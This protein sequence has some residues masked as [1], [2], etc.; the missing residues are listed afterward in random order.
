LASK[1]PSPRSTAPAPS[2]DSTLPAATGPSNA[3]YATGR[4]TP[5]APGGRPRA[6]ASPPPGTAT[7]SLRLV[8]RNG[9]NSRPASPAHARLPAPTRPS[10]YLPLLVLTR[11][12]ETRQHAKFYLLPSPWSHGGH[13]API[14]H[15]CHL[16]L[17]R[18]A[19]TRQPPYI[20]SPPP[21]P[22][23]CW[24]TPLTRR[25]FG[26]PWRSSAPRPAQQSHPGCAWSLAHSLPRPA[27]FLALASSSRGAPPPPPLA[28]PHSRVLHYIVGS[29][30]CWR[31]ATPFCARTGIGHML[32]V[33][34]CTLASRSWLLPLPGGRRPSPPSRLTPSVSPGPRRPGLSLR[35]C[36]PF[37][38]PCA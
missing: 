38:T 22:P 5:P 11:P 8:R 10:D 7:T 17:T 13:T 6:T 26:P 9:S 4:S 1:P 31:T 32:N 33:S 24:R 21:P 25:E 3:Q 23:S 16:W 30:R 12:A 27:S 29:V 20:P 36:A 18:P 35:P 34:S 15:P 14:L 19:E 37:S 2:F 28:P